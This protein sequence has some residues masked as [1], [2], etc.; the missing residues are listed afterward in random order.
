MAAFTTTPNNQIHVYYQ[1]SN[2]HEVR[3]LFFN[4]TSWSD[5]DL[6]AET[7][8]DGS[9]AGFWAGFSVGNYQYLFYCD[10][11]SDLHE[12]YYDNITWT[13]VDLTQQVGAPRLGGVVPIAAF[14]VPGTGTIEVLYIDTGD[15]LIQI[16]SPDNVFWN[17][18]DLTTLT[19]A[20]LADPDNTVV[21]FAT[22]PNNQLHVYYVSLLTSH[23]NQFFFNG[24]SWSNPRSYVDN[25]CP[26]CLGWV[27]YGRF[28]SRQLSVRV[29]RGELKAPNVASR[30]RRAGD[31]FSQSVLAGY[32]FQELTS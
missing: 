29:L 4:G 3:Q 22:T 28:F 10:L 9:I 8:T 15:E 17:Q 6:S 19:Q 23:V 2:Y 26:E 13:D 32:K 24:S 20:D 18:E 27:R 30:R 12:M 14:V 11:D 21:A 5:E 1:G 16:S 25:P 31:F 7:G